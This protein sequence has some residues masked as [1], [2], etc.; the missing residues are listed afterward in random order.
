VLTSP[1]ESVCLGENDCNGAFAIFKGLRKLRD[2][3][4]VTIIW[5]MLVFCAYRARA[6]TLLGLCKQVFAMRY[7]SFPIRMATVIIASAAIVMQLNTAKK[8][9]LTRGR[10]Q[11][12]WLSVSSSECFN[13]MTLFRGILLLTCSVDVQFLH[14]FLDE[15]Q[16]NSSLQ[17][18]LL[19]EKVVMERHS[20]L[21]PQQGLPRNSSVQL[22]DCIASLF[23]THSFCLSGTTHCSIVCYNKRN[24]A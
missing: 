6:P 13:L 11:R 16:G 20:L 5:M 15:W 1:G 12:V 17:T 22:Q 23:A 7:Q 18:L 24:S 3:K 10:D 4:Q 9:V 2:R 8:Q 21:K 19:V 14:R